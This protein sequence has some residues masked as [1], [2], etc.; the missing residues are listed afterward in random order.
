MRSRL[1]AAPFAALALVLLSACAPSAPA[2]DA[3]AASGTC[4][5]TSGG[6]A[7]RDVDAPP[8]EPAQSGTVSATLQ[9][10]A[11]DIP[12]TLDADRTPCTVGSFVSL[13]NQDYFSDTT[14]HRLTTEGIYVL[15]C[16][17][18]SATGM[19]GPGY[20][21]ADELDGSET[22]PAGT[23]AMANAGANT[24]GSQFFL[25]YEDSQLPPSY[26]VFGTMDADG[27]AVVQEIAAAGAEGGEP[28]GP[29]ATPVTITGV[30]I[31]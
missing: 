19:G 8:A 30:T 2:T 9:T 12:L 25:V 5:Y 4:E 7:A 22:Y 14:C 27:L 13:A 10:S 17:D 1:L 21:F 24:N 20:R 26:T 11:G 18:P 29:P 23:V 3:P 15:Q 28:D 16:G 31:G 6:T